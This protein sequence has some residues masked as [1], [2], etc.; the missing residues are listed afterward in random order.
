MTK[1]IH[2]YLD[3]DVVN[4]NLNSNTNAPQLRFEENRNTPF[5]E[6]DSNEYF[7]SIVRFSIQTGNSLPIF[8]PRVMTGQTDINK[9][10]YG[11]GMSV[12]VNHVDQPAK[13]AVPAF[14]GTAAVAATGTTP[15]IP[16]VPATPAMPATQ[17]IPAT[18]A[19]YQGPMTNLSYSSP[20]SVADVP[21]PPLVQQDFTGTY[22]YQ[23]NIKDIV[24]M[25][26]AGLAAAW[27]AFPDSIPATSPTGI[28]EL[29]LKQRLKKTVAPYF[30]YDYDKCRLVLS[31]DQILV[32]GPYDYGTY[33]ASVYFN[34]RFYELLSGLPCIRRNRTGDLNYQFTPDTTSTIGVKDKD[35]YPHTMYQTSQEVSSLA[36]WNPIASVVFCTGMLPIISTNTSV[37]ITYGGFSNDT[38]ASN[39]NNS[40]LTNIISDFEI[41]VSDTNQY[42]PI[43]VYNPGSEYRLMDLHSSVNLNKIDISVFWK[44]QYGDLVPLRLQPGCAAHIKL[45]FRH[46]TFYLGY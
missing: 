36:M 1:P 12:D 4:N 3:L 39:G 32:S 7:C 42:R 31:V 38:L 34:T 10:V 45:M 21:Q 37:P 19:T 26:N 16:A 22:Y 11:V 41:A 5:L 8:I 18:T 35:G 40:N 46:K 17:D 14:A 28:P 24:Q 44:T 20:D 30:Q 15:A 13:A 9:T 33:T 23:Y 29:D 43:I 25:F 27:A 6:G 2:T